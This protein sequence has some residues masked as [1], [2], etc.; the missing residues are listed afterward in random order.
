MAKM[1]PKMMKAYSAYEKTEPAKTKKTELKKG[2][3]AAQKKI[4]LKK[5]M[6]LMKGKAMKNS[7]MKKMGKKK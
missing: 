5:G 4:E 3:S 7:S 1:S 6:H 2:E